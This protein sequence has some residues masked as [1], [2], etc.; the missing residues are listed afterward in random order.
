MASP[1]RN[2]LTV[3]L[4]VRVQNQ[5][6]T[7]LRFEYGHTTHTYETHIERFIELYELTVRVLH[8]S[9]S[10]QYSESLARFSSHSGISYI[11]EG[12]DVRITGGIQFRTGC[13]CRL[14]NCIIPQTFLAVMFHAIPASFPTG[15]YMNSAT[16]APV[17][18]TDAQV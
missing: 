18:R 5:F 11:S 13:S 9:Y 4:I 3:K 2:D 17:T 6:R 8:Y 12:T 7:T 16:C 1:R 14:N 15:D 10:F